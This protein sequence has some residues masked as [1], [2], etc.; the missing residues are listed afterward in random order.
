[1]TFVPPTFYDGPIGGTPITAAVLN[2]IVQG[3]VESI[4]KAD[5]AQS[6]AGT[7][8]DAALDA[9]GQASTALDVAQAVIQADHHYRIWNGAAW[10]TRPT[11]GLPV[12]WVGGAAP[13][14]APPEQAAGDV[15]LP[16]T[17]DG[18]NLGAV[19]TALQLITAAANTIPYF[20]AAGVAGNLALSTS[21][22]LGTSDTTVASQ[23]AVKTYVDALASGGTLTNP[24]IKNYTESTVAIGNTGTAQT[25]A[26]TNG[27]VQTATLTGNCTFT[28]PTPAAGKSF[29]LSLYTGA[30]SF[31]ATFTSVKWPAGIA[32]TITVT[33]ARMD[34]L[35]FTSDGTNWYGSFAQNYTP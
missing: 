18:I 26:L 13:T 19:L 30:G 15:W 1:M 32:P 8:T 24:T 29:Q 11:D 16:S 9:A 34:L 21:G 23:K 31:T 3:I 25:L 17:G 2:I 27:T 20:S 35:T 6:T 12:L 5:T 22:S 7:A 33:A 28:M 10:P 4:T 14:D